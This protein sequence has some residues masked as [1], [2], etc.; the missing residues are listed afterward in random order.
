VGIVVSR[1]NA[2]ITDYY[3]CKRLACSRQR[4]LI[5]A[6]YISGGIYPTYIDGRSLIQLI[7]A[8]ACRLAMHS[9]MD[10][11][12]RMYVLGLRC[13]HVSE[14]KEMVYHIYIHWLQIS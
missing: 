3:T 11:C 7:S 13:A 1:R 9:C 5:E 6:T 10:I 2:R 12:L 14:L 4:M 8:V